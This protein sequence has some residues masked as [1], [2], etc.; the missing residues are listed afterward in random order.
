MKKHYICRTT[1]ELPS[2]MQAQINI[3]GNDTIAAGYVFNADE[4]EDSYGNVSVYELTKI[5]DTAN[6]TPAILLNNG[7]EELKDKRRPKGNSDYTTYTYRNGEVVTAIRL[8]SEVKLEISIDSVVLENEVD[9]VGKSSGYLIPVNNDMQLHY[10][11]SKENIKM[12]KIFLKVE[13]VKAFRLGGKFGNECATTFVARVQD[14]GLDTSDAT[15][16]AND[17]VEGKTAYVNGE[18][19]TGTFKGVDTS[20]ATAYAGD[21]L[22]GKTAYAR[23]RE[24][25]GTLETPKITD[26]SY[27]FQGGRRLGKNHSAAYYV[28]LFG[29]VTST[30]CMFLTAKNAGSID[31]RGLDTSECVNMSRM[32][33]DSTSSNINLEGF[34]TSNVTDMSAMFYT[35]N[36]L[37]SLD[38]SNFNTKKVTSMGSM[39]AN[40]SR[41]KRNKIW[42]KF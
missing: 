28:P 37:T 40:C 23:G 36:R 25:V 20:L 3:S 29:K 9:K 27:F 16:K 6:Q 13:A 17:I 26:A 30:E 15:A 4:L 41:F 39:F 19:I 5:T 8:V 31:L 12:P 22:K 35:C 7:I 33:N 10:Y 38:L 11:K 42:R 21:L 14:M 18:K 24:I 2:Y 32:F 1:T 34:N